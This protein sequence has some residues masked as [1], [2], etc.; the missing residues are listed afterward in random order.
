M[1]TVFAPLRRNAPKK[2][3]CC[4]FLSSRRNEL[5]VCVG[6]EE[7]AGIVYCGRHVAKERSAHE[8][9]EKNFIIALAKFSEPT[10]TTIDFSE[11]GICFDPFDTEEPTRVFLE[12]GH[13]FCPTCVGP[14]LARGKNTCPS[15]RVVSSRGQ[16]NKDSADE[17]VR[18]WLAILSSF[19]SHDNNAINIR[20]YVESIKKELSRIFTQ[21]ERDLFVVKQLEK[22]REAQLRAEEQ[23]RIEMEEERIAME[24]DLLEIAELERLEAEVRGLRERVQTLTT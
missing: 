5:C 21:E 15:C 24:Q 13:G 4:A 22:E 9:K 1:T 3:L 18:K 12:C 23:D 20:S 16:I 2:P 17:L 8:S 19:A 14:W 6:K 11:C 10:N 7:V